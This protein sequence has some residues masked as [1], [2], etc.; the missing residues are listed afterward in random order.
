MS[1]W[2]TVAEAAT[3]VKRSQA[4]IYLWI[5]QRKLSTIRDSKG[6]SFVNAQDALKVE[7]QQRPGR[8]IGSVTLRNNR[9]Q[10]HSNH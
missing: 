5:R 6:H 2:V 4:T 3:L 9:D 7:S 10:I 1:E 8:P